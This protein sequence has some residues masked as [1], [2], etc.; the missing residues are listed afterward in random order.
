MEALEEL[1]VV[2][3][4][5]PGTKQYNDIF[6]IHLVKPIE[7]VL[8]SLKTLEEEL[9]IDLITKDKVEK[10]R[11]VFVGYQNS[12]EINQVEIKK[13][14][15]LGIDIYDKNAVFKYNYLPY[16]DYGKM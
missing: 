12:I 4:T 9:G 15:R 13:Y 1:T 2:L 6:E 10:N 11:Y 5:N 16:K 7:T 8:K 3:E 14:G